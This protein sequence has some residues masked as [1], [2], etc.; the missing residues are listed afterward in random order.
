MFRII[1]SWSYIQNIKYYFSNFT[2]LF[3]PILPLLLYSQYIY[4]FSYLIIIILPIISYISSILITIII[5]PPHTTHL[6]LY[7]VLLLVHRYATRAHRCLSDYHW[8]LYYITLISYIPCLELVGL[9]YLNIINIIYTLSW[10]GV[11]GLFKHNEYLIFYHTI[12]SHAGLGSLI[13]FKA[14]IAWGICIIII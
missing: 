9:V 3:Y 14:I 2:V 11:V 8:R 4:N 12:Y 7:Q 6:S 10:V 1:E 13:T 5:S